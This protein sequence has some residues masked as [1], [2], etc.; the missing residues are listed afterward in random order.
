MIITAIIV[1]IV[2]IGLSLLVL[3]GSLVGAMIGLIKISFTS[4]D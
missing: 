4:L 1:S 2:L 3:L